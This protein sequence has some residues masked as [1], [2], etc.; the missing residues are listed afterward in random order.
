MR[1]L[2]VAEAAL[3]EELSVPA[4]ASE[5]SGD[6]GLTITEDPLGGGRV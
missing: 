1:Y 6:G 3:M 2:E 4:C 5:P